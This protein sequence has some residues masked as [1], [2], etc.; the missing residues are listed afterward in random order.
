MKKI[1]LLI[2]ISTTFSNIN[3]ALFP[4]DEKEKFLISENIEALA[5]HEEKKIWGL[6]FLLI[7]IKFTNP[8]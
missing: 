8:Y 4:I 7:D 3:Y 6:V 5:Y 2:I 1:I